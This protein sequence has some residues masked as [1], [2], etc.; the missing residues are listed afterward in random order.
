MNEE[1]I[2]KELETHER[3][4]NNHSERIDKLEQSNVELKVHIQNL[5]KNLESLTGAIKWLIGL[6]VSALIGFFFYAIQ[7]NIF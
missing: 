2:K 5:C 4:I 6:C 3:R 1:L 7:N